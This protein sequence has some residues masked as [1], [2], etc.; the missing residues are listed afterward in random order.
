[1]AIPDD[2][3]IG[4]SDGKIFTFDYRENILEQLKNNY[5]TDVEF[6]AVLSAECQ[7]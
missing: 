7:L 5:V 1:M 6:K 4:E 2:Y 3:E